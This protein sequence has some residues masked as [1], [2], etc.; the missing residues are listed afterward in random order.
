[1]R[2]ERCRGLMVVDHFVDLAD[3]DGN[4]WLRAWRCVNCGAVVEPGILR[5]RTATPSRIA[6]LLDRLTAKA[7]RLDAAARADV[8]PIGV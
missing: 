7:R 8:V 4:L 5:N 3:V 1:M 6:R 2:C